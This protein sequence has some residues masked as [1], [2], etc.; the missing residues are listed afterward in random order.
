V[1]DVASGR[2][3][4]QIPEWERRSG[5]FR[6]RRCVAWSPDGRRVAAGFASDGYTAVWEVPEGKGQ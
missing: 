1:S 3:V 5:D 6:S 4:L 2:D